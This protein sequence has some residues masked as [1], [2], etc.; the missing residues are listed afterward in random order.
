[1]ENVLCI[2]R[3]PCSRL[4]ILRNKECPLTTSYM[5]GV[6]SRELDLSDNYLQYL[7]RFVVVEKF[8]KSNHGASTCLTNAFFT[9]IVS[10]A[11]V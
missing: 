6:P 7:Y 3:G 2:L 1:M 9:E 4:H 5:V 8:D 11:P 10:S